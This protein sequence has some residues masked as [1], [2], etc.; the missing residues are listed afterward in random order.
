MPE[1]DLARVR[2]CFPGLQETPGVLLD[3]AGGSQILGDA[4][5]RMVNYARTSFVQLGASYEASRRAVQ[6]IADATADMARWI[7][8]ADPSEVVIGP[9]STQLLH[10]LVRSLESGTL[11]AGDE[12]IVTN[13]DHAANIHVWRRLERIGVTVRTWSLNRDTLQLE[14]DDLAALLSDKTRVVCVTAAS[15]VLGTIVPQSQIVERAH[16]AGAW[17]LV[18]AVAFAPHRPL[19]AA[20]SGADFMVFS[21]Y[22]TFGP[23]Q[24]VLWGRRDLLLQLPGI[25]HDFIGADVI[26]YKLQPGNVNHE[27]TVALGAIPAYFQ[28]LGT[29]LGAEPGPAAD[30]AAWDAIA[31]HE[32]RLSAV[33]LDWIASRTDDVRVIGVPTADRARRVSTIS[34][35]A[36]NRRSESLVAATDAAGI[37]IRWGHFYAPDLIRD[38]GLHETDGVVRVSAVHYNTVDEMQRLVSVL[39]AAL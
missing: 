14:P 11:S 29:Q 7:G 4:L 32:E 10:N 37:G 19:H 31:A 8:A 3:N 34:F 22:K 35:V 23:H 36:A 2:A 9:S 26:P 1:L 38:L 24:A 25:N 12:V 6:R 16:A 33:V 30:A 28:A 21:T 39:D 17:V 27:Q 18:D 13:T 15:N 20:A 5:E